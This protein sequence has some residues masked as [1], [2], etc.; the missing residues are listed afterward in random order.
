M[1]VGG[2]PQL[3]S[4][5]CSFSAATMAPLSA[6]AKAAAAAKAGAKGAEKRKADAEE[7]VATT[8]K[9]PKQVAAEQTHHKEEAAAHAGST[10]VH[11]DNVHP[12]GGVGGNDSQPISTEI[13][14][15]QPPAANTEQMV[16]CG[17]GEH[18]VAR[19]DATLLAKSKAK[20]AGPDTGTFRCKCCHSCRQRTL[21]LMQ[22]DEATAKAWGMMSAKSRNA[23][24]ATSHQLV[25]PDLSAALNQAVCHTQTV[26]TTEGFKGIGKWMDLEELEKHCTGK[27][28]KLANLKK[29]CKQMTDKDAEC[30]LYRVITYESVAGTEGTETNKMER[31]LETASTQKKT[32]VIKTPKVPKALRNGDG[33]APEPKP[34][35]DKELERLGKAITSCKK[36]FDALSELIQTTKATQAIADFVPATI[37]QKAGVA[38]AEADVAC[39]QGALVLDSKQC[40]N[41]KD[42]FSDMVD[43]RKAMIG[44]KTHMASQIQMA[45]EIIAG[46]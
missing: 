44:L 9:V 15:F 23:F 5:P 12:A 28:E 35:S 36:E 19:A 7:P 22:G 17:I 40:I 46:A 3:P 10:H 6:A 18:W 39:K 1:C 37:Q 21:E 4:L 13:V 2:L 43:C 14:V 38:V 30:I 45:K 34:L 31:L 32:K 8:P 11:V 33:Q 20:N 42:V 16:Y 27:P 25:G 26:S 24:I 29:N 41:I